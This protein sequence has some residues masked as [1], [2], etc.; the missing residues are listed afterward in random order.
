MIVEC[1]WTI[2][3]YIVGTEIQCTSFDGEEIDSS[4]RKACDGVS[5]CADDLDEDPVICG[6]V[7]TARKKFYRH[8]TVACLVPII[9]R[10]RFSVWRFSVHGSLCSVW[11]SWSL[12]RL[13]RR[14]PRYMFRRS[15]LPRYPTIELYSTTCSTWTTTCYLFADH[16]R[17][18]LAWMQCMRKE[19]LCDGF[20]DC[21]TEFDEEDTACGYYVSEGELQ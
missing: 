3:F 15:V 7:C 18:G 11:R 16:V 17:C 10:W 5:D 2:R 14:R 6:Y 13:H 20:V 4:H 12:R 19:H 1:Y 8:N 9:F 21:V